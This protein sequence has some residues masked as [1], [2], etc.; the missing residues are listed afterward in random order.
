MNAL[1]APRFVFADGRQLVHVI[2]VTW[3]LLT[4]D[5]KHIQYLTEQQVTHG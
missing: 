3:Q 5:G 4:I 1:S 2:G